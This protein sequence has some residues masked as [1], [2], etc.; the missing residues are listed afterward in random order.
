MTGVIAAQIV[1]EPEITIVF[2]LIPI[3]WRGKAVNQTSIVKYGKI[4]TAPVP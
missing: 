3:L 1:V 4:E 2:P